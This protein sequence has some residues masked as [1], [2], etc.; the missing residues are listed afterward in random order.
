M[1]LYN[2]YH[3]ERR[4][5]DPRTQYAHFLTYAF[6]L[7]ICAGYLER[8]CLSR[9]LTDVPPIVAFAA[10]VPR[11]SQVQINDSMHDAVARLL[12]IQ[13][14]LFGAVDTQTYPPRWRMNNDLTIEDILRIRSSDADLEE[15]LLE[16]LQK[17]GSDITKGP[18]WQ[19]DV[20]HH[21]SGRV[22][23][24]LA[25]SHILADGVGVRN[26]MAE[27]LFQ[28]SSTKLVNQETMPLPPPFE[29]TV[30][31]KPTDTAADSSVSP[32][33]APLVVWPG[34]VKPSHI[35]HIRVVD[36]PPNVVSNI[37]RV[38]RE[39]G[40]KTLHPVLHASAITALSR[41]SLNEADDGK[42]I[43]TNT[44]ISLREKTLGHPMLPG[45]YVAELRHTYDY[46][47]NCPR[48]VLNS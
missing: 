43:V 47:A 40:V 39:H 10:Q 17:K 25:M 15:L 9:Y 16:A 19:V 23:I 42:A 7:I 28:I 3:H 1:C 30:D 21:S 11:S 6:M 24:V 29:S 27:L 13:P 46:T 5:D 12:R 2:K 14:W 44:P 37:K 45:N 35:G 33:P 20:V 34:P 22:V 18:L 4:S 38:A 48:T 36:L 26:T 32:A 8:I 41:S 31:L